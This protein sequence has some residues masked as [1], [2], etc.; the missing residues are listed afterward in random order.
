MLPLLLFLSL[1]QPPDTIKCYAQVM[2]PASDAWQ[3][4]RYMDDNSKYLSGGV[5]IYTKAWAVIQRT[6]DSYK[7]I[8]VFDSKKKKELKGVFKI[9]GEPA[10]MEFDW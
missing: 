1:Q 5:I 10:I 9:K 6:P 7:V 8:T 2:H 4:G 3:L